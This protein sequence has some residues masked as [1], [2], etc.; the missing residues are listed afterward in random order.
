LEE[1]E[2]FTFGG[3]FNGDLTRDFAGDLDR[4]FEFGD[5]LKR[6]S[7]IR[8]RRCSFSLVILVIC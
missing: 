6:N 1:E 7:C 8:R 4:V 5:S 2:S 3:D